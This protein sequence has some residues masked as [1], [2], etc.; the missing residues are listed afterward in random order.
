VNYTVGVVGAPAACQVSGVTTVN[1]PNCPD[2]PGNG[3]ATE[4]VVC[5]NESFDISNSS[6]LVSSLGYEVGYAITPNP[7]SAYPNTSALLAA[8]LNGPNGAYAAPGSITPDTYTNNGSLF[9]PTDPC[10]EI[11]YFTPFLS[12]ACQSYTAI[13]ENGEIETPPGSDFIAGVYQTP[14]LGGT[15]LSV[16]Q[17][18]FCNGLVSYNIELCVND[19]TDDGAGLF[20]LCFAGE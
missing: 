1:C 20:G 15:S 12:F 11:L 4:T 7:P 19:E 16:P 10:G 5:W 17:V 2:R 9:T 6:A 3:T 8:S 13:N 14:G 18:P